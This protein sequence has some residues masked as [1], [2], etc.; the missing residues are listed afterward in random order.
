MLELRQ[1]K[2]VLQNWDFSC[3][4]A[5]LATVL[6]YQFDDPVPEK[7]IVVSMLEATNPDLVVAREGFSML[8]LKRFAEHRGYKAAGYG[9]MSLEDL[10][11]M[12]P[13]IVPLHLHGLNHFVV[14]RGR[15]GNR[16]LIADPVFGNWVMPADRFQDIWVNRAGFVVTRADDTNPINHLAVAASDFPLAPTGPGPAVAVARAEAAPNP[17][18]RSEGGSVDQ[19]SAA[20]PP[21]PAAAPQPAAA[22]SPSPIATPPAKPLIAAPSLAPAPPAPGAAEPAWDPESLPITSLIERG[23]MLLAAGDVAGA[24]RAYERAIEAGSGL[25]L[26]PLGK[27]HDPA[28]FREL[29]VTGMRPDAAKALELYEKAAAMGMPGA[30]ARLAALKL[31]QAMMAETRGDGFNIATGG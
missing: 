2:V 1:D 12:A 20:G 14:Y 16:I 23:D 22:P 21:R 29:G 3:G 24:R 17:A 4:A 8:D 19:L 25:A 10:S 11:D 31:H 30:S 6:K 28:F 5:A 26:L 9:D 7:Q 13:V 18:L 27:T 15:L